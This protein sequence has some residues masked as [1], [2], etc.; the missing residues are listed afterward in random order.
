MSYD[1]PT[2]TYVTSITDSFGY[3]STASYDYKWGKPES[4]TDINGNS[5][6]YVYDDVGRTKVIKGPYENGAKTIEFIYEPYVDI[7][8]ANGSNA[9]V[10]WAKTM[11]YDRDADDNVKD[12]I[13]TY[14]IIDGLKRVLQT[15]KDVSIGGAQNQSMTVSGRVVFDAFG[16]TIR[17]YYPTEE[18][19]GGE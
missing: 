5:I 3:N 2:Q 19:K 11:H 13:D 18:A 14:L 1:A 7:D 9:F 10:S 15:K 6:G 8:T 4:T 17:Q 12:T 16:R